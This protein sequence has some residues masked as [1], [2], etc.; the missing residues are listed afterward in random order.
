MWDKDN[1]VQNLRQLL[2]L[3][4][5]FIEQNSSFVDI[6]L[7]IIINYLEPIGFKTQS[8]FIKPMSVGMPVY[9]KGKTN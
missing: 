1:V 5:W 6:K 7:F 2:C 8:N 9:F 4:I 3:I